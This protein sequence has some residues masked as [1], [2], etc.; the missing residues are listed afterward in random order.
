M[1]I[2]VRHTLDIQFLEPSGETK[3]GL[4][5]FGETGS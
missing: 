5:P 4:E 2:Q 1:G 3:Y